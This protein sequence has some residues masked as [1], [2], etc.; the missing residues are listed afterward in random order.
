MRR[1]KLFVAV[2]SLLVSAVAFAHS[3]VDP[4]AGTFLAAGNGGL[5]WF[6]QFL[7]IGAGF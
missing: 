5:A 1:A 3:N 2:G 7:F 6:S 4:I